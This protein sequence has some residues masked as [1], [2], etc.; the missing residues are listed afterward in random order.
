MNIQQTELDG[1]VIIEPKIFTD[2]RG[3]FF[4]SWNREAYL[5]FG[6][7]ANFVQD[8]E[9]LSAKGVLRGLHFQYPPWT[10]A[11]LVRVIHGAVLDVAVD[12][13]RN[14]PTR[15]RHV[16]VELTGENR[17]QLF[18]P[19]GYAHGFIAL[20]NDTIVAYKCDN[21]YAPRHEGGITPY[22]EELAIDWH[23]PR[24]LH[25]VSEKDSANCCLNEIDT[26]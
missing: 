3:F 14:S 7:D 11:K 8:N 24:N 22:D 2:S 6:I 17:R 1:V 13:Q 26:L 23:L 15:G 20:E 5:S 18:I 21:V 10:Q 16:M 19:R 4:E 12:I 9:S 25:I